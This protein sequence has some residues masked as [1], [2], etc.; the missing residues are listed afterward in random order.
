MLCYLLTYL[1][2]YYYIIALDDAPYKMLDKLIS[3]WLPKEKTNTEQLDLQVFGKSLR[4][5]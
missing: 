2:T 3:S 4:T 1:L 5:D